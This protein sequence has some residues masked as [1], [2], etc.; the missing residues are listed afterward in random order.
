MGPV[1][2][3]HDVKHRKQGPADRCAP[4]EILLSQGG[5]QRGSGGANLNAG[6][7]ARAAGGVIV[8]LL[9]HFV[10]AA[11]PHLVA[12]CVTMLV[13]VLVPKLN[14]Q[15]SPFS[16][17]RAVNQALFTFTNGSVIDSLI[18]WLATSVAASA[19]GSPFGD[20][21]PAFWQSLRWSAK[22]MLE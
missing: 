6:A 9:L 18:S 7:A 12:S 17:P 1:I 8:P 10:E 21:W 11:V 16:L 14:L 13:Q 3:T 2:P 5:R 20:G 4:W 22:G 15:R 19:T